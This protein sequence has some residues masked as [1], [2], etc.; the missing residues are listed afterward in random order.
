MT[1]FEIAFISDELHNGISIILISSQTFF[2]EELKI[3]I[4]RKVL[5]FIFNSFIIQHF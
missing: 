4:P 2:D 1:I 3:V 5:S